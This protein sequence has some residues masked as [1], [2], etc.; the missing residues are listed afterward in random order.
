[1]LIHILEIA[2]QGLQNA[3]LAYYSHFRVN[4]V[5]I[6]MLRTLQ[7]KNSI[8]LHF[9]YVIIVIHFISPYVINPRIQCYFICFKQLS[10]KE[11]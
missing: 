10:F 1:M 2:H 6:K 4:I 5:S 3:F 11:R 9:F 8:S 7:K